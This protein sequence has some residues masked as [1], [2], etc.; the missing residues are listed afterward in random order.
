MTFNA[1][2]TTGPCAGFSN[3]F[4]YFVGDNTLNAPFSSL[5]RTNAITSVTCTGTRGS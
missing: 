4:G 3:A 5:S 2:I 1:S